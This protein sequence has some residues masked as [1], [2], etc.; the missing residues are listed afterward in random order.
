MSL[1]QLTEQLRETFQ[2]FQEA[3]T[4]IER[5]DALR[6]LK[7]I[8]IDRN[9]KLINCIAFYKNFDRYIDTVKAEI[10]RLQNKKDHLLKRK[11]AFREYM[12]TCLD[13]GETFTNGLHEI[14]WR[15]NPDGVEVVDEEAIPECYQNVKITKTPDKRAILRDLKLSTPEKP[16]EIPGAVIKKGV[17]TIVIK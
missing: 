11:E 12:A 1:Y 6:V 15:K 16:V 3:E 17:P 9:E 7:L 10:E 2:T 8:E 14:T 4:D 13:I 5:Q